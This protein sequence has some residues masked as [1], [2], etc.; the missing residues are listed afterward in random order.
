[1]PIVSSDHV[2]FPLG[3][4]RRPWKLAALIV[5]SIAAFVPFWFVIIVLSLGEAVGEIAV[6]AAGVLSAL[7][8][9]AALL[10]WRSALRRYPPAE[11]ASFRSLEGVACAIAVL[12]ALGAAVL[13]G[14]WAWNGDDFA[15]SEAPSTGKPLG[16]TFKPHASELCKRDGIRFT[17]T[18]AEG[19]EV[20][21]TLTP[22]GSALIE[23]G[24]GFVRASG[25]PGWA[26][27]NVYSD[28]GGTVDPSGQI[29]NVAGL[30]GTIRGATAS[31]VFDDPTICP[32]KK[33]KWSAQRA[34]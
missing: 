30:T 4:P 32:G 8:V 5:L 19:A 34:P 20:C 16:T 28:F 14:A 27:G 26:V 21:F 11:R 23:T 31:G 7:A 12:I 29:E 24:Y 22:D 3:D 15:A 1:M 33:F 18:T 25:C 9:L 17:G 10:D 2:D 6:V 13:F